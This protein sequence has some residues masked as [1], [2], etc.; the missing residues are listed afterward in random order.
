MADYVMPYDLPNFAPYLRAKYG[1]LP[2][3]A[4][5]A[6]DAYFTRV[7]TDHGMNPYGPSPGEDESPIDLSNLRPEDLQ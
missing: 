1:D 5:D 3:E 2:D 4:V 6:V 7:A